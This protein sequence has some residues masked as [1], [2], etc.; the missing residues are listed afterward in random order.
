MP[1]QKTAL[2]LRLDSTLK[3]RL[4]GIARQDNRTLSNL[5]ETVMLAYAETRTQPEKPARINS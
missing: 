4:Q 2:N 5:V 1:S 3:A